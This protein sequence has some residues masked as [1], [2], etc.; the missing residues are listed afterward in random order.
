MPRLAIIPARGGSKR[1]PRKNIR[2]FL[3][4]PIIA[5][6]IEAALESGLF[7]QV[8]V[9]TDDVQIA[10]IARNFGAE[11]PFL[12]S[13]Q[14]S[15][16]TATTADVISEVLD[17]YKKQHIVWQQAACIYPCAPFVTADLLLQA[18]RVLAQQQA[19]VVFPVIRYGHP[20]QR[21]L[22]L[23]AAGKISSL[24]DGYTQ[25]RTQD[26]ES[27]FHDAG[28]FYFFDVARFEQTR[29]LRTE[30][31]IAIEIDENHAQDI[32][33]ESDWQLAELKY[34]NLK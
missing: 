11:T 24:L 5:Y 10:E 14:N 1:I 9:S 31:T 19:D 29:S 21:A 3:G 7:D 27:A 30:N 2:D 8:I 26:L 20:I 32:D 28:M 4:K 25:T 18:S 34:Q 33:S 6:A 15:N 22:K 13:A 16:D 23:D 12:R 17:A